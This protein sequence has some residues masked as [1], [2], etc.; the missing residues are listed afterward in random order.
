MAALD[1]HDGKE[2]CCPLYEHM[3]V[4]RKEKQAA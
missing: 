2:W 1:R 4:F 3:L